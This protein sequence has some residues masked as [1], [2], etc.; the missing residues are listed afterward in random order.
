MNPKKMNL[1]SGLCVD[2]IAMEPDDVTLV[3]IAHPLSL[4]CRGVGQVKF[5]FSVAQHSMNCA[6]EAEARGY[7]P[8]V[9]LACLLHDAG[10]AY[11]S[12]VISPIK[13]RLDTYRKV[14]KNVQRQVLIHFGVVDVLDSERW[15][16]VR[17]IDHAMFT[18][19]ANTLFTD[20]GDLALEP[21]EAPVD[22]SFHPFQE[23]EN[24]F[25]RMC[26]E[27]QGKL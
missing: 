21:L 23:V 18:H 9:Q 26:K 7:E 1:Y 25:T 10:E 14:E 13:R 20:A 16:C 17:D 24:E 27:L 4:L 8:D 22:I 19:E 11:C 3:D 2:P 12:D 6:K 5:F 15:N